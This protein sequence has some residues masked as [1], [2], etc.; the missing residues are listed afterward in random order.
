ML[1]VIWLRVICMIKNNKKDIQDDGRV[2]V[3]M[4]VEGMP[5]Y[6]PKKLS[7]KSD[8]QDTLTKSQIRSFIWGAIKAGLLISFGFSIAFILFILFCLKVWFKV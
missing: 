6:N 5:W 4:N 8:G 3:N 7:A 2:I 1:V